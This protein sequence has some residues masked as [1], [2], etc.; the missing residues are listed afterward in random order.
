[1]RTLLLGAALAALATAACAKDDACATLTQ[2]ICGGGAIACDR[3][4]PWLAAQLTGADGR[5]LDA[6]ARAKACGQILADTDALTG[7]REAA[8][9][10]LATTK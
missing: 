5:Q 4:A 6:S 10:A 1:M 9:S 3:V 7:F 8:T 2:T